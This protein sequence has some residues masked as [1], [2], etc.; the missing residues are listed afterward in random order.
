MYTVCWSVCVCLT[1]CL[2]V[3][4][5][6]GTSGLGQEHGR[7][8]LYVHPM[9]PNPPQ[10]TVHCDKQNITIQEGPWRNLLYLKLLKQAKT[11]PKPFYFLTFSLQ[12]KVSTVYSALWE[13]LF[14]TDGRTNGPTYG[15]T[16]QPT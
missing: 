4:M 13:V 12:V 9:G 14:Q 1:G 15:Q 6:K 5:Q 7:W 16:D 8:V 11:H 3:C 2:S 10:L